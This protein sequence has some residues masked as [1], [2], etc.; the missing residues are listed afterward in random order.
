M[1][2]PYRERF[3]PRALLGD[4]VYRGWWTRWIGEPW[5]T[6]E[7]LGKGGYPCLPPTGLKVWIGE[8]GAGGIVIQEEGDLRRLRA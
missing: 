1:P 5:E 4:R 3:L 7:R 2:A 8:L 6:A